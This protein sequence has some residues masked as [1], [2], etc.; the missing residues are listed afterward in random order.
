MSSSNATATRSLWKSETGSLKYNPNTSRNRFN[1]IMTG[2]AGFFTFLALVP[3]AAVLSYLV[4]QGVANVSPTTILER[5]QSFTGPE[6]NTLIRGFGNAI[7]GT[8][9]MTAIGTILSVPIGIMAGIYLSEFSPPKVAYWIRFATNV[10]SGVPSIIVGMFVYNIIVIGI[11]GTKSSWAGGVALA[12][13]M[14]PII[15]RTT[16]ESLKLIPDAIRQASAGVGANQYQTVLQIVFPSAVP[17]I[18]T[19]ITLAVARAAGETAPLLFTAGKS[20]FWR[21][22][23]WDFQGLNDGI[24]SLP[25]FIYDMWKSQVANAEQLAWAASFVLMILVMFA[26]IVSRLAASKAKF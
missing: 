22:R 26:N 14:I 7:L 5:S 13:L 9:I 21:P 23:S 11:L 20:D 18:V 1:L 6:G 12:I 10:L 17:A 19:G 4:I 15:V 25:V 16:D 24:Y 3:L 2:I 8:V